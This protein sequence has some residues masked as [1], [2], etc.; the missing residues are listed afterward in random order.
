MNLRNCSREVSSFK[1]C[2]LTTCNIK[3]GGVKCPSKICL[4]NIFVWKKKKKNTSHLLL[5][6]KGQQP[7]PL[8]ITLHKLKGHC[9]VIQPHVYGLILQTDPLG[10]V[11]TTMSSLA[12][13]RLLRAVCTTSR[14]SRPKFSTKSGFCV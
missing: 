2:V 10:V 3:I 8:A 11:L 7:F 12:P 14:V 13:A 4:Q 5:N 9:Q 1:V 6:P